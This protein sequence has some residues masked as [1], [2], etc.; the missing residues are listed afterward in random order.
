MYAKRLRSVKQIK[1][2]YNKPRHIRKY[3]FIIKIWVDGPWT[4]FYGNNRLPT[5]I[6]N[7]VCKLLLICLV[8]NTTFS[9]LSTSSK[10]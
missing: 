1:L 5:S 4:I 2:I 9:K 3:L 10:Y 7:P 6:N 8:V